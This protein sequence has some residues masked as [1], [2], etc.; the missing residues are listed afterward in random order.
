MADQPRAM[1]SRAPRSG[2]WKSPSTS[3]RRKTSSASP[4]PPGSFNADTDAKVA[5][6][7][8]AA[9][10]PLR[11]EMDAKMD[12]MLAALERM[13]SADKTDS[14]AVV[15]TPSDES[16]DDKRSDG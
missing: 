5:S 3:F 4:E 15:T 9:V 7:V 11:N 2:W 16:P 13:S 12:R 8:E 14:S 10:A 1:E 6:A